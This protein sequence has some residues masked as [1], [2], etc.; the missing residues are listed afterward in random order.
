M[1]TLGDRFTLRSR[2]GVRTVRR[3]ERVHLIEGAHREAPA[4][5]S[6]ARAQVTVFSSSGARNWFAESVA[7]GGKGKS[8]TP[9]GLSVSGHVTV[10]PCSGAGRVIAPPGL[11]RRTA[12]P[13][14]LAHHCGDSARTRA[15]PAGRLSALRLLQCAA[16]YQPPDEVRSTL[17]VPRNETIARH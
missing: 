4:E 16:I 15:P 7:W 14:L 12:R 1:S 3:S 17:C 9:H 8:Q 6:L 10:S 13:R 2:V 5:V 11:R